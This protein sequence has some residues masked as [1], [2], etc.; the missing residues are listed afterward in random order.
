MNG[1]PNNIRDLIVEMLEITSNIKD[2]KIVQ[3]SDKQRK[4]LQGQE[5]KQYIVHK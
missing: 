2:E 4:L 5:T 1:N 3:L